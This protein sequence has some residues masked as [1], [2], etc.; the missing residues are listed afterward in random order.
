MVERYDADIAFINTAG[1]RE[2][3]KTGEIR[4]KDI[5]EVF[6]FDNKVVVV[7][8]SGKVFKELYHQQG[9]YLYFNQT[10]DLSKIKDNDNYKIATIDYVYIDNRYQK[11]FKNTLGEEQDLMRDVFID[12]IEEFYKK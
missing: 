1:V 11:Y 8:I 9:S 6:P 12:Y 2:V 10:L 7:N 3:I 5:F 4:V